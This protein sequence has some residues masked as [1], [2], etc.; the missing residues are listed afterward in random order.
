MNISNVTD[1]Y[2]LIKKSNLHTFNSN[3][4]RFIQCVDDYNKICNC[5]SNEKSNKYKECH[6]L[7]K[8]HAL[9][10]I[11]SIKHEIFKNT[12]DT[13]ILFYDGGNIFLTL[14]K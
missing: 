9:H 14:T 4:N 13:T 12:N 5:K 7:Y 2:Y 11:A 8:N 10:D 3:L 1:F 6:F